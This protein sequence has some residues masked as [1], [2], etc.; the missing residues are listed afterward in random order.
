M[1]LLQLG[2]HRALNLKTVLSQNFTEFHTGQ[3]PNFSKHKPHPHSRALQLCQTN[4]WLGLVRELDSEPWNFRVVPASLDFKYYLSNLDFFDL[5]SLHSQVLITWLKSQARAPALQP[6]AAKC[7]HM[8]ID[9]CWDQ[10]RFRLR[11]CLSD[12]RGSPAY[13]AERELAFMQPIM[14]ASSY[15]TEIKSEL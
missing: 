12:G 11:K 3:T 5:P 8:Y 7:V 15:G 6:T 10:N 9:L 4:V 2:S 14:L 1:C 13:G